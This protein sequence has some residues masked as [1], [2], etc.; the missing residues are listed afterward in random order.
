MLLKKARN[1][2]KLETP[3]H[4]KSKRYAFSHWQSFAEQVR[5]FGPLATVQVVFDDREL[6][7]MP[8]WDRPYTRQVIFWLL[9]TIFEVKLAL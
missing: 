4:T 2:I 5:S 8:A 1:S 7:A 9:V 3:Y 6:A